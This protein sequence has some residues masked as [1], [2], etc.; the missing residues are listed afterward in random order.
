MRPFQILSSALLCTSVASAWSLSD[1]QLLEVFGSGLRL[2]AK[3]APVPAVI[4][5]GSS[6]AEKPNPS[7]S[8]TTP[9]ATSS[10]ATTD[11]P[12]S[13][14]SDSSSSGKSSGSTSESSKSGSKTSSDNSSTTVIDPRLP[15]GGISMLEP[16]T[17]LSTQYYKIG[18]ATPITFAWNYTSLSVTPTAIDILAT[19]TK[20]SQPLTL[21]LN[22]TVAGA[23][24]NFTWDTNKYQATA[25]TQLV[26]DKYTLI[27]YDASK[28]Q[29]AV[30][31]S[32]YLATFNQFTFGMYIPQP[33]TELSDYVCVTCSG[34][35]GSFERQSMTVVAIMATFAV[36]GGTWFT[37]GLGALL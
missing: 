15:P 3:R 18:G 11:A 14:S 20:L 6:S 16:N 28:S 25:T 37:G 24:G 21:A 30:P 33:Y 12:S 27:I 23:T 34:A 2:P 19:C 35:L 5:L 17:K 8:L 10:S 1:S 9:A 36:L 13:G 26:T 32:G 31:S 4:S 7:E 22:Q 29:S